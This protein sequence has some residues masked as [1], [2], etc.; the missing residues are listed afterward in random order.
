MSGQT[1]YTQFPD[2][3]LQ[4]QMADAGMRDVVSRIATVAITAGLAVVHDGTSEDRNVKLPASAAEITGDAFQGVAILD[5]SRE[6]G[7][8]VA[9]DV[10]PVMRKGRIAV[11]VEDAV[12][13]GAPVFVRYAAGGDGVGSFR[14]D[15]GTSEAAQLPGAEYVSSAGAGELAIVELT[16]S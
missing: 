7:G 2:A 13:M 11:K 14:S 10:V 16:L 15:A 1:T 4:G 12:T 5:T 8:Y 6:P 9:E 3:R